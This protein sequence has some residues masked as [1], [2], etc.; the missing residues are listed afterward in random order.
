MPPL[1][2][3]TSCRHGAFASAA[4]TATLA[5][6]DRW[7]THRAV[8]LQL[9]L[10]ALEVS[11]STSNSMLHRYNLS[12]TAAVGVASFVGGAMA[13][14]SSQLVV[15]PIDVVAQRLMLLGSAPPPG[16]AAARAAAKAAAA[17]AAAGGGADPQRPQRPP[18]APRMTGL[19]LARQIVA[20]EGVRG[21]YRGFGA[22]L[23]MFVP[24]S[25]IWWGR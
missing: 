10:S 22:S 11:K 24:N 25:A 15:V 4:V 17:G 7:R 6:H 18:A 5:R 14:L 23:A 13:S 19:Q 21:L 12:D 3:R 20:A 1:L 9:Y 8:L 16:T 2:P